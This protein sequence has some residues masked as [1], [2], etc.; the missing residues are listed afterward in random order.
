MSGKSIKLNKKA[1]RKEANLI[2]KATMDGFFE[3]TAGQGLFTRV[4]IAAR[5]LFKRGVKATHA[6][7]K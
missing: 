3:W 4:K 7:D 6:K 1:V 5:V 2:R